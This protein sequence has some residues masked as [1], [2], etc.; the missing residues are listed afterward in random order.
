MLT[1]KALSR[2]YL[3]INLRVLPEFSCKR[4]NSFLKIKN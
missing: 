3:K 2:D 4:V 1:A